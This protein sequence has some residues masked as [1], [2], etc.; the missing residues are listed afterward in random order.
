MWRT[1]PEHISMLTMKG[2]Q[3]YVVVGFEGFFTFLVTF[4]SSSEGVVAS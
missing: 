4:S 2:F 3:G 1:N